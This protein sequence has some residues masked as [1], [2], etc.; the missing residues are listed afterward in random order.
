[1]TESSWEQSVKRAQVSLRAPTIKRFYDAATVGEIEGGFAVLLDGRVARTPANL[2]LVTPTRSLTEAI[3]AEWAAQ[4]ETIDAA[5]M[6][7]TRLANSALDGVARALREAGALV[8]M[9]GRPGEREAPLRA[10]GVEGFIYAGCDALTALR[11][12]HAAL[13]QS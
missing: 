12:A 10:A 6:P 2:N 1:M 11:R 3:A 7:L 8:W 4:G 13:V 9:A 5:A